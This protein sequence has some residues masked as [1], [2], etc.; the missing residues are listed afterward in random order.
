MSQKLN[1]KV[2]GDHTMHCAGCERSINFT[3]SM[4]PNVHNVSSDWNTQ[5]IEVELVDDDFDIDK[6]KAELDLIGY[7]VELA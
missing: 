5:A 2:V 4:L 7:E 3:L 6:I 1:L